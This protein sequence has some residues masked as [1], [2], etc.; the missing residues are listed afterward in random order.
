MIKKLALKV[1]ST[2][3]EAGERTCRIVGLELSDALEAAPKGRPLSF[4]SNF[5]PRCA[6]PAKPPRHWPLHMAG[7]DRA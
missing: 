1:E 6:V 3:S 2:K 7:G 4:W 5:R